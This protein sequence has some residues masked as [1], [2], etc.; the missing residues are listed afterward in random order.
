MDEP[1]SS[2]ATVGR[3]GGGGGRQRRRSCGQWCT[4][5]VV[6]ARQLCKWSLVKYIYICEIKIHLGSMRCANDGSTVSTGL[7]RYG[8]CMLFC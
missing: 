6:V 8:L 2:F 1:L 7:L 4:V 5:V 3:Y